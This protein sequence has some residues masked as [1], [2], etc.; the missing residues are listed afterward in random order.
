MG[1]GPLISPPSNF[2]ASEDTRTHPG[3][4]QGIHCFQLQARLGKGDRV[5]GQRAGGSAGWW[6]PGHVGACQARMGCGGPAAWG[7]GGPFAVLDVSHS[8]VFSFCSPQSLRE[9]RDDT[10]C[11]LCEFS[12][13][14]C[15]IGPGTL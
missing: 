10:E 11:D 13:V 5:A 4:H 1:G 7:V 6:H 2:E 8:C 14:V 9:H 12:V 3:P 15:P